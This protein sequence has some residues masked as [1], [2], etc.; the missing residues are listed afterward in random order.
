MC[1]NAIGPLHSGQSATI[2]C[3]S[4]FSIGSSCAT[5]ESITTICKTP[6]DLGGL[7]NQLTELTLRALVN[8]DRL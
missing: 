7:E 4:E 3:V 1:D 8:P 2:E 6:E 5:G